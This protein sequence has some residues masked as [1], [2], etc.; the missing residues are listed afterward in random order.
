MID[1]IRN[2]QS[3]LTSFAIRRIDP[4]CEFVIR[5]DEISWVD[6]SAAI[7][8]SDIEASKATI[9]VELAWQD[10]RNRRNSLLLESDWTQMPDV[11]GIDKQ[12]WAD[13]RQALRDLPANTT[14]PEN[15]VWPEPPQA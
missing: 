3:I 14:D 7:D 1:M 4:K 5:G 9:L 10:F 12:A 2:N 15:P 8:L 13:Y 6:G 11:T